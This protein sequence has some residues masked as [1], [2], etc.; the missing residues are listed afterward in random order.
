MEDNSVGGG[1][2]G[3]DYFSH[4]GDQ[5]IAGFKCYAKLERESLER[6]EAKESC[7][8]DLAEFLVLAAAKYRNVALDL[9]W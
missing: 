8:A 4:S 3:T 6:A 9:N 1:G 7:K 5:K 2:S